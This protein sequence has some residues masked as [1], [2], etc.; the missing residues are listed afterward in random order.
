MDVYVDGALVYQYGINPP[1]PLF[2]VNSLP[3][4]QIEAVEVY[5][6]AVQIPAQFNTAGS[7]CG[8]LVI[9]TRR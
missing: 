1:M 6:S 7:G 9:W 2:N 3:P 8:V 5:T 4:D